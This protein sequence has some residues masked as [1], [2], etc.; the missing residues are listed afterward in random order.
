MNN[1]IVFILV[2]G[3]GSSK[4]YWSRE[5][6]G[7]DKLKYHNFLAKLKKIGNVYRS[8]LKHFNIDYYDFNKDLTEREKWNNI[9]KTYKPHKPDIMFKI[10]D[11]DYDQICT[12]IHSKVRK[13][14]P[15]QKLIPIGHSYGG[16]LV[17][18]FSKM[19]P[20]DCLFTVMLDGTPI[21]KRCAQESYDKFDHK[22]EASVKKYLSDDQQLKIALKKIKTMTTIDLDKDV[23]LFKSTKKTIQRV[24]DLI[25]YN[26]TMYRIS[27][28]ESKLHV[29][30]LFF[31]SIRINKYKNDIWN[32]WITKEKQD[33]SVSNNSS[34]YNFTYFANI[35][36][37]LWWD[38]EASDK[39]I[40]DIKSKIDS[41]IMNNM[42][43]PIKKIFLIRHGET[44]HNK[45][46]VIQGRE[47]DSPLNDQGIAQA[48]KTGR[49]LDLH[50]DEDSIILSSPQLRAVQTAEILNKHLKTMLILNDDLVEFKKGK[51]SGVSDSDPNM[52]QV[53]DAEKKYHVIQKDPI[54]RNRQGIKGENEFLELEL[55][56]LDLGIE[57]YEEVIEKVQRTINSIISNSHSTIY[58]V[59]HSGFLDVLIKEM[60]KTNVTFNGDKTNGKNCWICLVEYVNI[61]G[62][63]CLGYFRLVTAPNT[64]HLGLF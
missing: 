14:Y 59:S 40:I 38:Q 51:L 7:T 27:N 18:Q 46:K 10:K 36:H 64:E 48:D 62:S 34:M 35:D 12:N 43:T 30:T 61:S 31:K 16:G 54:I 19:Y 49:Y 3:F 53:Y 58:L 4:I 45:R 52:I 50:R 44:E 2:H 39:I 60:F 21:S 63:D 47:I 42:N 41:M 20:N 56:H 57:P 25:A 26:S 9:Y 55:K 17:Y 13:L 6:V 22:V 8:N 37:Y 24:Y 32:E 1:D 29:P 5:Y 28:I 23:K 15:T 33:I 11:L